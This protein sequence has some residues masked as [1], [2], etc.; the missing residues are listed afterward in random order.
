[1]TQF[2]HILLLRFNSNTIRFMYEDQNR[3]SLVTVFV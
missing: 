2:L 3:K 1:M